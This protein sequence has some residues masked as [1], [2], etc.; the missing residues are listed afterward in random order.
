MLGEVL[1]LYDEPLSEVAEALHGIGLKPTI[2]LKTSGT[3]IE[4]LKRERL[5]LGLIR[6]IAG[7][8]IVQRMSLD[9]QDEVRDRI[10]QLWPDARVLDRRE[11]PNHGYRAVHVVPKVGGRLVEIQIRTLSQNAWAQIM[12]QLADAYGREIRYGGGP[13]RPDGPSNDGDGRT[14]G[15]LF[16]SWLEMSPTL[17]TVE[18]LENRVKGLDQDGLPEEAQRALDAAKQAIEQAL[19]PVR[20]KIRELNESFGVTT[21]ILDP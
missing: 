10:L 8:R 19:Q 3:L 17:A 1:R 5:H 15:D 4:K 2:R 6:D 9:E 18:E 14:R 13:D 7:A 20:L 16:Q 12:E 11:Q 21:G